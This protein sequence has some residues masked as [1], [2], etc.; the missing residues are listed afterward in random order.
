MATETLDREKVAQRAYQ[1]YVERGKKPGSDFDD[2]VRA[3]KEILGQSNAKK[4]FPKK[5]SF[6]N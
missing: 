4:V 5:K 1:I 3:E 2:W 6:S